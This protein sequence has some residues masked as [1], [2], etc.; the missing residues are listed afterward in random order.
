MGRLIIT[1]PPAGEWEC[2]DLEA[3]CVCWCAT[4]SRG[5][6]VTLTA[7]PHGLAIQIGS[8]HAAAGAFFARRFW[9]D[10]WLTNRER[11]RPAHWQD[12][13]REVA[14]LAWNTV[15]R[16]RHE[17]ASILLAIGREAE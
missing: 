3:D 7:T 16:M 1:L 12:P 4:D 10:V 9:L 14:D 13:I 15:D 17:A 2:V 8:S 11:Q 6:G 5:I